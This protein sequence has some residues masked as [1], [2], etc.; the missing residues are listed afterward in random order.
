MS[1]PA[2]I[3]PEQHP[4]SIPQKL[5]LV[6]AIQDALKC[7]MER[8]GRI[9]I[10]GEDVGANGGVFRATDHL[11]EAFGSERVMDTPLGESGILGT[12]V[13]L[14]VAGYRPVAEIQFMGFLYPAMNQLFSHAARMRNR[15]RGRYTVPMVVRIPHGGGIHPPEH[16]SESL[17]ALI[18]NTPG[19]K[20]VIPSTPYDAKGLLISSIRDD[21]PVVFLEPIRIYRSFREDVP[22]GPYTVPLGKL[23]ITRQGRDVTL[24]SYGAMVR[25][26]LEAAEFLEKE[27][28]SA[29]VLD[30]RTLNPLDRDAIL[31]SVRRTGRAVIVHEAP[32]TSGFGAELAA[33]ISEHAL[34]NLLAPVERVA[35][36]DTVF[37]FPMMEEY[38]LPGRERIMTAVRKTLEF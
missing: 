22:P 4:A 33:L 15:S 24:I 7:E 38:Y 36:F 3:L 32:R 17:E 16:H 12:A 27:N 23:N 25:V 30:L 6:Q 13:G 34:L 18:L 8:D 35:G 5:T 9:M 37:P 26:C 2:V 10:L 21:D 29:E 20:V 11:Q 14:A 1:Q 28:I 19:L 31:E